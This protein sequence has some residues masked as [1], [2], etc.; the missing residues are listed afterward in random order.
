MIN[1][2]I[3]ILGYMDVEYQYDSIQCDYN[4]DPEEEIGTQHNIFYKDESGK[5]F[6]ITATVE[7]HSCPS[8]WCMS[9]NGDYLISEINELPDENFKKVIKEEVV[10]LTD[11]YE[12]PED[13]YCPDLYA[14]G[15][16]KFSYNGGDGWYPSGY[17]EINY[18]KF[19]R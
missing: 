16:F 18:D 9:Y 11:S 8:G 1:K 6:K 19:E 12:D 2:N 14:D 15:Y 4:E 7:C 17:M 3:T 13:Y 10:L 5:L